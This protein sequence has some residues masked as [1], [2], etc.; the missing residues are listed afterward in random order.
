MK[1]LFLVVAVSAML[2]TA[3]CSATSDGPAP[4]T[5][6][7]TV[8]AGQLV[9][10]TA[11]AALSTYRAFPAC[12]ETKSKLCYDA[13]VDHKAKQVLAV[14]GSALNKA[15][16]ASSGDTTS[17]AVAVTLAALEVAQTLARLGIG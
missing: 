16:L 7:K 14:L 5:M 10:T 12:G 8:E 3:A 9:Y 2:A 4:L 11:E 6:A 17:V 1:K 15:K 13:N